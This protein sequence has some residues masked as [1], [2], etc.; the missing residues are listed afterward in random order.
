MLY[1]SARVLA[2]LLVEGRLANTPPG[3]CDKVRPGSEADEGCL[4]EV[5]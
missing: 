2:G 3:S 1:D 5:R 4:W